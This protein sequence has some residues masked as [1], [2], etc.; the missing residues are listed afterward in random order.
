[1]TVNLERDAVDHL[2]LHFTAMGEY[3]HGQW[4]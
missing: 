2:W 4:R 1:M 3:R